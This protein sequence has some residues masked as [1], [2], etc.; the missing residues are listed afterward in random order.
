[1]RTPDGLD[2]WRLA[3]FAV[4]LAGDL[5]EDDAEP[6]RAAI[7]LVRGVA[8]VEPVPADITRHIV[9]ERARSELCGKLATLLTDGK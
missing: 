5:R 1:M 6:L 4:T 3:G 9:D 2:E 7:A 8:S